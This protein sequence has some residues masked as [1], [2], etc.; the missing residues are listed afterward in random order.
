MNT[1]DHHLWGRETI[2]LFFRSTLT[3]IS[4]VMLIEN[5]FSGLI[6]LV[7]ITTFSFSLGIIALFSS[8]IGAFIGYVGKANRQSVSQGLL[9]YNSVLTGIAL[10]LFLTGPFKWG[11]ALAGAAIAAIL[12]AGMM[13]MMKRSEL[14]VLTFPFIVLTWFLLL[15]SYRLKSFELSSDLFPQNLSSLALNV[16]GKVNWTEGVLNGIGQIFFVHGLLSGVLLFIAVFLAGLRHGIYAIIGN[17]TA[18]LTAHILGAEHTL[19]YKGLYGYNAILAVLAVS[20]VFNREKRGYP[21]IMG[22]IAACLTVPFSASISTWLTPYGLPALTMPFVL[23]SW[24]VIAAQKS[25]PGQKG[26]L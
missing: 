23:S 8:F 17:A 26:S 16:G 2:L 6:I 24:L 25:L 12:T 13:K 5:V 3:G 22:I 15:A 10:S 11:I 20:V 4:Q 21:A 19:I 9:G 14:P 18:L 7:A 1:Y